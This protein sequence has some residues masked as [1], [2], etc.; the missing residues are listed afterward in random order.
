MSMKQFLNLCPN[1]A[2]LSAREDIKALRQHLTNCWTCL[3]SVSD[4][5]LSV[6]HDSLCPLGNGFLASYLLDPLPNQW[7]K[8]NKHTKE[9]WH[10]RHAE[11]FCSL[12]AEDVY[13][14]PED[15]W[16]AYIEKELIASLEEEKK[17]I[18]TSTD[19]DE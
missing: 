5:N 1:G 8:F 4:G 14:S 15:E 16:D 19:E 6:P 9:C 12:E 2:Q 11:D 10:C 17:E 18:N 3:K 13:M 7:Q